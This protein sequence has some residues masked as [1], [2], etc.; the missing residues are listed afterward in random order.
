VVTLRVCLKLDLNARARIAIETG[1]VLAL[2][3][4][5][6][7][8][9]ESFKPSS[10][11]L[12]VR[13]G[14]LSEK[15]DLRSVQFGACQSDFLISSYPEHESDW[16]LVLRRYLELMECRQAEPKSREA[17]KLVW[18]EENGSKY[19]Q[20]LLAYGYGADIQ[21]AKERATLEYPS[22]WLDFDRQCQTETLECPSELCLELA[23]QARGR[24][25]WL[26]NPPPRDGLFEA[27]CEAI[28]VEHYLEHYRLMHVPEEQFFTVPE[29]PSPQRPQ[30]LPPQEIPPKPQPKPKPSAVPVRAGENHE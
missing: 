30:P 13:I 6:E 22:F 4:E 19:L 15:L 29:M 7:L 14:G 26:L 23:I 28:I 21:Y 2:E 5:L 17:E 12:V 1:R 24:A 27:K 25:V 18:V 3:K 8:D 16:V 9:F 10:R 11:E 20:K